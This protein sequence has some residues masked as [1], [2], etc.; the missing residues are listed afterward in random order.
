MT[1]E[2][3]FKGDGDETV[4]WSQGMFLP[5]FGPVEENTSNDCAKDLAALNNNIVFKPSASMFLPTTSPEP[6]SNIT[7]NAAQGLVNQKSYIKIHQGGETGHSDTSDEFV[8][9]SGVTK[10]IVS[11][12]VEE[13]KKM[14]KKR[15]AIGLIVGILGTA[16]VTIAATWFWMKWWMLRMQNI[17]LNRKIV[18]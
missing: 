4:V 17:R 14:W 15:M 1:V 8:V 3:R 11:T 7:F 18:D 13:E 16:G 5:S 6:A 10:N 2:W 9:L 12:A